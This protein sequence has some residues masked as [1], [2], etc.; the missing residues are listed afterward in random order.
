[1]ALTTPLALYTLVSNY[2][3]GPIYPWKGLADLHLGFGR[4]RQYPTAIWVTFPSVQTNME[5]DRWLAIGC[6]LVYF[7]LFGMTDTARRHYVLWYNAVASRLHLPMI[8]D[9]PKF[10][11]Y[12]QLEFFCAASSGTNSYKF[13]YSV[14]LVRYSRYRCAQY[15]G[16][17]VNNRERGGWDVSKKENEDVR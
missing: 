14:I 10:T 1:M 17:F 15:D 12:V 11:R 8:D 16:G 6:A 4:V 3:F 9:T 5:M 7:M 13:W 2:Y